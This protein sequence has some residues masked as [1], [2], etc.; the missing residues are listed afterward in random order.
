MSTKMEVPFAERVAI[1]YC[2]KYILASQL[3]G[4]EFEQLDALTV[5]ELF[6]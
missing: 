2:R 3:G 4:I 6:A 5:K 1:I